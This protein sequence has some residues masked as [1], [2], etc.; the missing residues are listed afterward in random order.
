MNKAAWLS[1]KTQ[2]EL[3]FPPSEQHVGVKDEEGQ[4]QQFSNGFNTSNK[5]FRPQ[6]CNEALQQII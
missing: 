6:G 2:H 5:T 1:P 3:T 4:S